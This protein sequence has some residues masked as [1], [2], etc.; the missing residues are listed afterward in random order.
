MMNKFKNTIVDEDT[1]L[2]F[3]ENQLYE[4]REKDIKNRHC[5]VCKRFCGVDIDSDGI[6]TTHGLCF[7]KKG[8]YEVH[9]INDTCDNFEPNMM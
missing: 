3:S 7:S 5:I 2:V 6:P 4:W 9:E 8:F 1:I